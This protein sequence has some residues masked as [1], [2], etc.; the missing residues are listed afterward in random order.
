MENNGNEGI[1]DVRRYHEYIDLGREKRQFHLM[2]SELIDNSIGSFD[3]KFGEKDWKGNVL[4]I[5]IDIFNPINEEKEKLEYGPY[6]IEYYPNAYIKF[7]D[8]AYGIQT[9]KIDTCLKLNHKNKDTNS[10]VHQHGRG[11]KQSAFFLGLGVVVETRNSEVSKRIVNEP[12]LAGLDNE[13]HFKSVDCEKKEEGT[14]VIVNNLRVKRRITDIKLRQIVIALS[15]RYGELIRS[16][17][18]KLT[19]NAKI[20]NSDYETFDEFKKVDCYSTLNEDSKHSP[21]IRKKLWKEYYDK[22]ME[23]EKGKPDYKEFSSLTNST[24]SELEKIFLSEDG[25]TLIKWKSYLKVGEV[26]NVE[27]NFWSNS[28]EKIKEQGVR[29]YSSYAGITVYQGHRAILHPPNGEEN[30]NYKNFISPSKISGNADHKF[31]GSFN[32]GSTEIETSADKSN[33]EFKSPEDKKLLDSQLKLVYNIFKFFYE[34]MKTDPRDEGGI[35]KS[36]SDLKAA[37]ENLEKR[38]SLTTGK[39]FNTNPFEDKVKGI[40]GLEYEIEQRFNNENEVYKINLT[41]DPKIISSDDSI[42]QTHFEEDFPIEGK[43]NVKAKLFTGHPIWKDYDKK[44][45]FF[46][47]FMIILTNAFILQEIIGRNE[48]RK[49]YPYLKNNKGESDEKLIKQLLELQQKSLKEASDGIK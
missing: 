9:D 37:G 42:I 7:K 13:V 40:K 22:F 23:K 34:G 48:I 3:D 39:V 4:E 33:I 27:F 31:A 6:G 36:L 49:L 11:L 46:S 29:V 28:R 15:E 25:N 30:S 21:E 1:K 43:C 45:T 5:E 38:F 2:F 20:E 10:V 16:K 12:I 41:L 32:I 8:N 26:E 14:K 47:S 35:E 19:I 18:M 17:R 24:L 44:S